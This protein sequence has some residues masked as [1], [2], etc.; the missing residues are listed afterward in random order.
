MRKINAHKMV[1]LFA[2]T[3]LFLVTGFLSAKAQEN[4]TIKGTI[5]DQKTKAPIAGAS[6]HIDGSTNTVVTDNKG[7]FQQ[8]TYKKLPVTLLISFVGYQ[9]Q[10][11]TVDSSN[12]ASIN[13]ELK[14]APNQLS[15]VVVVGYGT[16]RRKDVSGSVASVSKENLNRPVTSADN[17]LQG[18]V[19]G[20]TVTQSSGQP[21]AA[22]S[23]RI[24]GGNSLSF[25]NDPLYVIDGFIYYNNNSAANTGS[26]PGVTVNAL[27]TINPSDIESI[28]VLKDA[29]ATAIYGSRGANG[30]VIITT[31]KGTKGSNNISYAGSYGIQ[32]VDKKLSLMNGPQWASLYD[33]IYKATPTLQTA[34]GALTKAKIDSLGATGQTADWQDAAIQ[35]NAPVQN[36]QLTIYGGDEKSRYSISGNYFKQQGI[37]LNSDFERYSGRAN[38]EKNAT[39]RLKISANVFGSNSTE[40]KLTGPF[41]ALN[42][43]N[44][45]TTLLGVSP[46]HPI[47]NADGTYYTKADP[48]FSNIN[49]TTQPYTT[50]PLQDIAK[51]INTTILT[52]FLGNFSAEYKLT[53]ELL[54][55]VT[56]GADFLNAKQN[57]YSPNFTASPGG[58]G[59][60]STGAGVNGSASV[61]VSHST[62]W[63][64]ENTLSYNHVF[65]ENHYLDLLAG[66]TIQQQNQESVVANADNF[67]TNAFTFNNLGYGTPITNASSEQTNTIQSFLG[68]INYSYKHKYNVSISGREDGASVLGPN[69]KYGFFPSIGVSW[70]VSD[71]SFFEKASKVVNN[72]KLRLTAGQT[73]NANFTPYTAP[74][75]VGGPYTYFFGN[76]LSQGLS[77]IQL[78]NPDLSWETTTQY[79]GGVDIGL[80]R[81]RI[82]ITA[83]A[84]YKKTT[85]LFVSA[86]GLIPLSTGYSSASEN[87]G[88]L[89]NKG[90]E[91]SLTTDNIKTKD[92]D[93]K[94]TFLYATNAN[95][96]LSL[97]PSQSF[98]PTAATGQVSP[99][100]IKVGLPIGTFWGY[101]TNGLLTTNDVYGAHPAPKLAGV[102]Q[103]T[104]DRKYVDING[105][106]I[107]NTN[108]KHNLGSAQA[109]FT[110]SLS[111]TFTYKGFDLNVFF[112][113]SFGNKIFNLEQQQLEKTTISGNASAVLLDRY[114]SIRNPNGKYPK[115]VNAPVVQLQDTYIEDGSYIRLKNITLGYTFPLSIASKIHAK[116]IRLYVSAQNLL[117]ITHYSGLDPEANYYDQNNLLPG[118]DAGVYPHY[119]TFLAGLNVTF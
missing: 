66:Y 94:T 46:L 116:Q 103:Q 7:N 100:I 97:G 19:S 57:Y 38:Y 31:K 80:F 13:V 89:E 12:M 75:L 49:S 15:D 22:S 21:G 87:I 24:R 62:S 114:D 17:L 109:K 71:E 117:T 61:G 20:V 35:T 91:L 92:F 58:P 64:N 48:F 79:N 1:K 8:T 29:S 95:K 56:A 113:G 60:N 112:Q 69:K 11:V 85:N 30:V 5:T 119:R 84:Y 33:D 40:N 77:S 90:I 26:N 74:A 115:A 6:I 76:N 37:I 105:D 99:E 98:Q 59:G 9:T 107:V 111:N 86:G 102:S 25:G 78:G 52:R 63:L 47:Y 34:A 43:G 67:P 55:K 44:G 51:T 28:D 3:S 41:N 93:W 53:R 70:N 73:G 104:G 83:D 16:Q 42:S 14:Y 81:N 36:H 32:Q 39:D 54:L 4:N 88:S 106:G 65:K 118:I 68:R 72:L 27:A 18:T 108:D 82:L 50:N 10:L 45:F 23:I 110:A 101:S 96:V 2:F